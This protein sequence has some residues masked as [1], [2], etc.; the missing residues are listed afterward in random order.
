MRRSLLLVQSVAL[1]V[2]LTWPLAAVPTEA[3]IG[4]PAGD[5][6]KHVWTLWWMRAE[7]LDGTPGL[8][9]RWVGWPY[10]MPLWPIEPLNGALAALLPLPPVLLANVLALLHLSLLGLCSGWL[11]FLVA[12]RPIAAHVAGAVAQGS[13]YAAFTLA[14]GAGELRTVWILPL[15]LAL[16]WRLLDSGERHW[17][18]L[19]GTTL[20]LGTVAC[21]YY[22]FFLGISALVLLC[23]RPVVAVARARRLV[24]AGALAMALAA[25]PI[26][27]FSGSYDPDHAWP[28]GSLPEWLLDPARTPH[29]DEANDVVNLEQL[30]VPARTARVTASPA[31]RAYNGGRYLGIAAL[32]LAALGVAAAPRRA[33]PFVAVGAAGIVLAGGHV[34]MVHGV[35]LRLEGDR[36]GLP[37]AWLNRGLAWAAHPVNF[38]ARFLALTLVA[39]AVLGGLATRWR[40]A[41]LLAPVAL[42]DVL[43]NDVVG[44]P[45][46]MFRLPDVT[47]LTPEPGGGAVANL[48]PF[49]ATDNRP[50]DL[51]G[52]TPL[53][54][55]DDVARTEAIAAQLALEA[56]FE[57]VPLERL[58]YWYPDGLLWVGALPL[59]AMLGNPP[60]TPADVRADRFL[61]RDAGFDR[62]L[63]TFNPEV[64]PPERVVRM[65]NGAFGEPIRSP[66][67]FVWHV[68]PYAARP[69]EA[70]RWREAHRRRLAQLPR[71]KLLPPL[72]DSE[73]QSPEGL[74]PTMVPPPP[75]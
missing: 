32:L 28:S 56:R 39:V 42:A 15:G 7:L 74:K 26:L 72:R 63:L 23:A 58:D 17:A 25:G 8:W 2:L 41:A 43:A 64:G 20:G 27:R 33:L 55:K 29:L 38:P 62:I 36:V 67:A 57:I 61:L 3:T 14:L 9:T 18:L 12:E 22:G 21:F 73:I 52:H 44:W 35:P 60:G 75:Q 49:M 6:A 45:R 10:G 24:L 37:L 53:W 13:S 68:E 16:L 30:V 69:E 11:A 54:R 48:T 40:R 66:S 59:A 34:V 31:A 46:P 1:A 5:V 71:P 19:F 47:G 51:R 4:S 50:L 65:M 70:A